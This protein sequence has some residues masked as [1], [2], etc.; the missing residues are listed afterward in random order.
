M[1]SIHLFAFKAKKH[2]W[3]QP[4]KG[5]QLADLISTLTA[6]DLWLSVVNMLS[7]KMTIFSIHGCE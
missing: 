3:K 6:A 2:L 7:Q 4:E 1:F 5:W